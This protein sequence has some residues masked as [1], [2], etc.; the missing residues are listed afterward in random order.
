MTS[1]VA[2][3]Y[4]GRL[5]AGPS[6]ESRGRA[7]GQWVRGQSPRPEAEAFLVFG[8]STKAAN[9]ASFLK[10]GNSK[11]SDV[12]VIFAKK[13]MGGHEKGGWSKPGG[14]CFPPARVKNRH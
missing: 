5:G 7:P 14:L 12:C 3:A 6:V 11:K 8:R 9:L 2:R 13:I 1:A 4:N 10:F